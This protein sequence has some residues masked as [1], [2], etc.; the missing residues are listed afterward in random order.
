MASDLGQHVCQF[1]FYTP[2]LNG[3]MDSDTISGAATP[4]KLYFPS[5]NGL[6]LGL[7]FGKEIALT[8][9]D[10]MLPAKTPISLLSQSGIRCPP[11]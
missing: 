6:G 2:D 8:Y 4:L 3:F 5:V 1:F 7:G 11:G 9:T 10:Y